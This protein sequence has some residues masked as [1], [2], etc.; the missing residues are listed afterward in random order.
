MGRYFRLMAL[1]MTEMLCAVPLS[2]VTIWLTAV[3]SP[4][5]PWIS[6]SNTHID[7][8]RV[9]QLPSIVYEANPMVSVGVQL[10][11]WAVVACSLIFFASFGFAEEA[12]RNYAMW[13]RG[14]LRVLE[15][16]M[17]SFSTTDKK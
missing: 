12:R 17:S 10:N 7:F 5:G 4:I 15:N 9:E 13:Y 11:R 2:V 3:D 8:S 1:A 14:V 16:P 6:L